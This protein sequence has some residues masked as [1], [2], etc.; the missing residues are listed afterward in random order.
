[1]QLLSY[2]DNLHEMSKLAFFCFFFCCFFLIT[3]KNIINLSPAEL[4]QSFKSFFFFFFFFFFKYGIC[5]AGLVKKHV[6]Q[7]CFEII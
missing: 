5:L 3:K 2:G 6:F 1:M 4:A 7:D